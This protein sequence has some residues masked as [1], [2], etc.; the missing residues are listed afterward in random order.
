MKKLLSI[1]FLVLLSPLVAS[2]S[3]IDWTDW[4]DEPAVNTVTGVMGGGI[5]V[6]YSG[7]YAFAQTGSGPNY[8]A[9]TFGS[10]PYTGSDVIDNAPTPAE[11]IALN[12]EA[13]HTITF[14]APVLNPVMAILSL[15]SRGTNP[16]SYDFGTQT[17][18]I[19]SNG[20]GY[21]SHG[22]VGVASQSGNIL[23][24]T[25]MHGAIQFDGWINSISWQSSPEEYWHGITVGAP[26]PVPEPATM[27]LFGAGLVGVMS[28]L[29]K[30]RK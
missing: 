12:L 3:F 28:T 15:G 11:M 2:A 20:V 14:S 29:R 23:T 22:K 6:T 17:F 25:E 19:L 8:W 1:C 4:Q 24:G 18:S 16:V 27:L 13:Y 10:F 9:E 30:K 21:W 5:S 7:I 26:N